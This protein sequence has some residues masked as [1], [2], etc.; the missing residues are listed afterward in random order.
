MTITQIARHIEAQQRPFYVRQI[1]GVAGEPKQ[2][3][4][5]AVNGFQRRGWTLIDMQ[6]AA[7]IMAV[8]RGLR[9]DLRP[10]LDTIPL[11]Q[12]VSFCWRVA[13]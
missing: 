13:A 2:Y 8:H 6:I 7:A 5:T 12:L 10:K 1:K 9:D 11:A 4:I 3:D